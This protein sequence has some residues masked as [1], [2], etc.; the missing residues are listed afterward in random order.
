[1]RS[2]PKLGWLNVKTY[3]TSGNSRKNRSGLKP[4]HTAALVENGLGKLAQKEFDARLGIVDVKPETG[5]ISFL[6]EPVSDV[7]SL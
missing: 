6:E 7:E 5:D 3:P 4:E 1:M 2:I